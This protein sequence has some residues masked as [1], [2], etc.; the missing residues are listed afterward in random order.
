MNNLHVK[1]LFLLIFVILVV[2]SFL[3]WEVGKFRGKTWETYVT[4]LFH[5]GIVISLGALFLQQLKTDEEL[6]GLENQTLLS[7]VDNAINTGFKKSFSITRS[8]YLYTTR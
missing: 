1:L 5:L 8:C 7:N 6:R 3:Y 4:T 2:Y